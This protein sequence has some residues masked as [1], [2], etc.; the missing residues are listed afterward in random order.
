[1]AVV[2]GDV[3]ALFNFASQLISRRNGIEAAATR[4]GALV[5][6]ANWVG[7]DRERFVGEWNSQHRPGLLNVC[8]D[9]ANASTRIKNA[10]IAQEQASRG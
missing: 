9:L 5:E 7:P 3:P 6:Q 1:M 8:N 4:L 2:G 10:A